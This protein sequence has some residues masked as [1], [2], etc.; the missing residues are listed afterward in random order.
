M[1]SSPFLFLN[2]LMKPTKNFIEELRWRGMLQ[3]IM[4]GAEELLTN[5]CIAGYAGFD[6][7]ADSLGIGNLVPIM[8]LKHFQ[9]CGHKPIAVVGGATGMIGDPSG[10]SAERNLLSEEIIQ[11]NLNCQRVQ[12]EKFLDFSAGPSQAEILNNIYW[13]KNFGY[14]QFLRD[15]GKHLSINYMLAK[16]SVQGRME[17]GISYTEFSYQILQ[18][19]DFYWLYTHY[20][21]KLQMGGSDQ[22]GNMTTGTELIRR[23]ATGNE[24]FAFTCP[25]VTKA[26]GTKFGKTESGNIWLDAKK[27]SPYKFYQFWLNAADADAGRYIRIFSLLSK[28]EIEAIETL[29]NA[30]PHKRILQKKL[31]EEITTFVHSKEDLLSAIKASDILFGQSTA[32]SLKTLSDRDFTEIF[33]GVPTKTISKSLVENGIGIMNL[34]VDQTQFFPSNGEAKRTLAGKGVSVNKTVIESTE[35]KIG[36]QE[37]IN[38]K[39]L[40]LQKGKKNYFLVVVE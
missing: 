31:A 38:N 35:Q 28:D 13:Y 26:D 3:D 24:A 22:W 12:L 16:D 36:V 21:C 15:V 23:M 9:L 11:H 6:P 30:E 25:L 29:H 18:G 33:E 39:Y 8:L 17:T 4:P 1:F 2:E 20:N 10:K 7:T 14:I 32:D 5:E 19:Y 37:L 40:L 34:L 27:T